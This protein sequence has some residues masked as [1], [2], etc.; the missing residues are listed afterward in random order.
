MA[1]N[2][3]HRPLFA[4]FS[5]PRTHATVVIPRVFASAKWSPSMRPRTPPLSSRASGFRARAPARVRERARD[6]LFLFRS[7]GLPRVSKGFQPAFGPRFCGCPTRGCCVWVC[8]ASF[9][10]LR[11][12]QLVA[13]PLRPSASGAYALKRRRKG[14]GFSS[15]V[16]PRSPRRPR[17]LLSPSF[18]SRHHRRDRKL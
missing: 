10:K 15:A 2:R 8:T 17:D 18:P 1:P 7:A 16:I 4:M 14:W 11:R 12:A 6:L 13:Q 3:R 5:R 9:R